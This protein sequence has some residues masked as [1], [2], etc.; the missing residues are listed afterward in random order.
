MWEEIR[1]YP[2]ALAFALI[3]HGVLIGALMLK[4]DLDFL[5]SGLS[6]PQP[7]IVQA[8][9]ID[10]HAFDE[11]R[12]EKQRAEQQKRDA[13]AAAE[14]R[15]REAARKLEEQRQAALRLKQE[16]AEKKRLEEQA[17]LER[18]RREAQEAAEQ[19]RRE[20][21][22]RKQAEAQKAQEAKAEQA[23]LDAILAAEEAQ[24]KA[25]QERRARIEAERA[26][27]ERKR[28]EALYNSQLAKQRNAYIGA[29]VAR[30]QANWLRPAED[31]TGKRALIAVRQ[32]RG[33]F[34]KSVR[35]V[36]CTGGDAFCRSVEA[37]VW[38][39]D[40]LPK[41]PNDD[42]FEEELEILFEPENR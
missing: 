27:A 33:G 9:A 36:N 32:A 29:I 35:I 13:A 34:I 30:V 38:K 12:R 23:R 1:R 24:I 22:A 11:A 8:V 18:K 28:Q 25:E 3:M 26:E 16:Q 42:V 41:P 20:E 40:P 7:R 19:K 39:S 2:Q 17:A 21:A 10:G 6:E 14:R 4:L 31:V 5:K 15:K 37:A